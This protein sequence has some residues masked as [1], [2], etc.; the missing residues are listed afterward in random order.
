M[1]FHLWLPITLCADFLHIINTDFFCGTRTD[2]AFCTFFAI[3]HSCGVS[4]TGPNTFELK[5]HSFRTCCLPEFILFL[6]LSFHFGSSITLKIMYISCVQSI[7]LFYF[8]QEFCVVPALTCCITDLF[9]LNLL[10]NGIARSL[11]PGARDQKG[12]PW[13]KYELSTRQ[14]LFI[15]FLLIWL[16]VLNLLSAWYSIFRLMLSHQIWCTFNSASGA[17]CI[18]C[19]P[20]QCPWCCVCCII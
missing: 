2:T 10:Y 6:F 3:F 9:N 16:I 7:L 5:G 19:N 18:T 4:T 13:E 8:R 12:C 15:A 11:V 1:V 14:Q 17:S 20:E